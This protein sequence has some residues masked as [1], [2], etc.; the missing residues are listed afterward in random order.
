[1]G[2][3]L[4]PGFFSAVRGHQLANAEVTILPHL[5]DTNVKKLLN[6]YE[7]TCNEEWHTY[8]FYG[9][10]QAAHKTVHISEP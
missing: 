3:R 4:C 1:M 10:K 2:H 8:A 9:M 6:F 7:K 5:K